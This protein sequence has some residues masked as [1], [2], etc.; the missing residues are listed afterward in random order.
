MGEGEKCNLQR[1]KW[2]KKQAKEWKGNKWEKEW[3][4]RDL[5]KWSIILYSLGYDKCFTSF[6][7]ILI[8]DGGER[9]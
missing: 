2:T 9:T 7:L 1:K 3:E 6:F 5:T 4:N 8:N